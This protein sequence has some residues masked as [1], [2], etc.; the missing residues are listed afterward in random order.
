[1][2][3]VE[4]TLG[5]FNILMYIFSY[6]DEQCVNSFEKEQSIIYVSNLARVRLAALTR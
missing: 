1:M 5:K 3:A 2:N 4:L 6:A